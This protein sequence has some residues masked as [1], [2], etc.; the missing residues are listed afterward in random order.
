MVYG[1][2]SKYDLLNAVRVFLDRTLDRFDHHED[3]MR[4][5]CEFMSGDDGPYQS[6]R[7]QAYTYDTG[8]DFDPNDEYC[9]VTF[10]HI[11]GYALSGESGLDDIEIG[12]FTYQMLDA[13]C[14]ALDHSG[15]FGFEVAVEY[16][17]SHLESD[18]EMF[19]ISKI[20]ETIGKIST[21]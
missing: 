1:N 18:Y 10:D 11:C 4:D 20:S 7:A 19:I 9:I 5:A 21:S 13:V 15:E 2:P 14:Q 17:P 8:D 16:I 6:I 3:L 12:K